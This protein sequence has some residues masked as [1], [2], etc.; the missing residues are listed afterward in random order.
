MLTL[1]WLVPL[2]SILLNA[3]SSSEYILRHA[4]VDLL[5]VRDSENTLV[6]SQAPL[7]QK[8]LRVITRF[9]LFYFSDLLIQTSLL[10][11]VDWIFFD[12]VFT[13]RLTWGTRCSKARLV[14]RP[15]ACFLT[16]ASTIMSSFDVLFHEGIHVLQL[17]LTTSSCSS[18]WA[19]WR[20]RLVH[21]LRLI[22]QDL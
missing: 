7:R 2:V 12:Q 22:N 9:F 17:F 10:T 5:I 14:E 13:S 18:L 8:E 15:H 3:C 16:T 1:L 6:T 21:V 11:L 20:S 19:F 4:K